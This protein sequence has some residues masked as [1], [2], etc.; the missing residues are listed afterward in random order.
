MAVFIRNAQVAPIPGYSGFPYLV[1]QDLDYL[2]L[3]VLAGFQK[4][5]DAERFILYLKEVPQA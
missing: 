2:N 5:E 1:C 4:V 3:K